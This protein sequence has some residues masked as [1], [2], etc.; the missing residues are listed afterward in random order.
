MNHLLIT[1]VAVPLLLVAALAQAAFGDFAVVNNT[2]ETLHVASG[3]LVGGRIVYTG[4]TQVD[5]G[6]SARVPANRDERVMLSVV[7]VRDGGLHNWPVANS[8]GW[9][10]FIVSAGNFRCE[11]R[12]GFLNEWLMNDLQNN[13]IYRADDLTPWPA[14]APLMLTTFYAV[15]GNRDQ[16]FVP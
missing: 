15:P 14:E 16:T 6:R 5:S 13:R 1:R 4:W 9:E 3:R 7:S 12:G 11:Q 8:L 10:D 2:Q